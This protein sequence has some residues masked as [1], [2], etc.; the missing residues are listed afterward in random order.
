M[1][2]APF[3]GYVQV[4]SIDPTDLG[5]LRAWCHRTG[6][7]LVSAHSCLVS[8][9]SLCARCPRLPLHA[10]ARLRG[11]R[12]PT[13]ARHARR[14]PGAHSGGVTL[15]CEAPSRRMAVVIRNPTAA[16][17]LNAVSSDLPRWGRRCRTASRTGAVA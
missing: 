7:V 15:T 14:P 16:L 12:P 2:S 13:S 5:D 9:R 17:G 11:P 8:T 3:G 10:T 6:E 1:A 4:S